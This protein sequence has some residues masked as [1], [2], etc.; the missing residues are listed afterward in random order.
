MNHSQDPLDKLEE[1]SLDI[2]QELNGEET[3][4]Q[5]LT[6]AVLDENITQK[7]LKRLEQLLLED[8]EARQT[9]INC[10]QMHA[11]LMEFYGQQPKESS[12]GKK[13]QKKVPTQDLPL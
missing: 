6:W 10:V 3:E 7:E 4:T 8:S 13:V 5:R 12:P 11:D 2:E 1:I 9:Y